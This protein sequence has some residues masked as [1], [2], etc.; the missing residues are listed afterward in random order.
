MAS[1]APKPRPLLRGIEEATQPGTTYSCPPCPQLGS[2]EQTWC[3][4]PLYP[5][6][7]LFPICLPYAVGFEAP[8]KAEP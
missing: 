6:H 8:G 5:L 1:C 7:A 2:G 3:V 4:C